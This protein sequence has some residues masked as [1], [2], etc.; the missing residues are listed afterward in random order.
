MSELDDLV[1][2]A[3]QRERDRQAAA[4]AART[5]GDDMA[6]QTIARRSGQSAT[7]QRQARADAA[8]RERLRRL[9]VK[10]D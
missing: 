5:E 3:N 9:G 8:E 6:D 7:E 10:F 1:T 4:E 2:E